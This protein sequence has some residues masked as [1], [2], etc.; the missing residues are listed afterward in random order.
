MQI[1]NKEKKSWTKVARVSVWSFSLRQSTLNNL[2][3]PHAEHVG[4]IVEN[5][6][7][8]FL[9]LMESIWEKLEI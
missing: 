8:I 3:K 7:I 9:F 1:K 6:N 2:N 5:I 4:F